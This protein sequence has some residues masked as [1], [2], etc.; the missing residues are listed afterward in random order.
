MSLRNSSSTTYLNLHKIG[1]VHRQRFPCEN[2]K[3]KI[4]MAHTFCYKTKI[5]LKQKN[6]TV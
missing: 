1:E 4:Y 6:V 3:N 2:N 5:T